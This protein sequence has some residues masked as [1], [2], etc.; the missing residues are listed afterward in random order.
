MCGMWDRR[1]EKVYSPLRWTF[2][3]GFGAGEAQNTPVTDVP[4]GYSISTG[5]RRKKANV[6]RANLTNIVHL[7][8]PGTFRHLYLYLCYD[9][10]VR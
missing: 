7:V 1:L 5:V 2:P 8:S 6:L 3:E 9:C 4:R 10:P